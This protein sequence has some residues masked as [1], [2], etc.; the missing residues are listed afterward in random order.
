MEDWNEWYEERQRENYDEWTGKTVPA[1]DYNEALY[2]IENLKGEI[3]RLEED[4][5][6]AKSEIKNL[7]ALLKEMDKEIIKLDKLNI[8]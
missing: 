6:D 3:S 4:L 8:K 7:M 1:E 2:E 5:K